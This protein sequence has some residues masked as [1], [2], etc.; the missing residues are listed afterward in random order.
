MNDYTPEMLDSTRLCTGCRKMRYFANDYKI[1]EPC[2]TRDI[3]KY[4]KTVTKCAHPECEFKKSDENEYCGKHQLQVFIKSTAELGKKVCYDHIRG[5]RAQLDPSYPFSKCRDCLDKESASDRKRRHEAM[6]ANPSNDAYKI[7]TICCKEQE[8]SMFV[9]DDDTFTKTCQTCRS[10]NKVQ[11]A[12]RDRD[13]RNLWTRTNLNRAFYSYQRDAEKRDIRFYLT[14]DE[15]MEI[16]K[17]KC[18]Y[19]GDISEEKQFN[20]IDRVDSKGHY[21]IDNCVSACTLCNY[22]KHAMPVE[23]FFQRIEHI[24]TYSGKVNGE[25]HPQ[26]FPNVLSG[27]YD[28]FERNAIDRNF[29]FQLSRTNFSEI[30]KNKC[31]LCGKQ[32]RVNHRNGV[33]RFNNSLGYTIEN[34]RPCCSTC[35]IMKNRYSY[36]DMIGKFEKIYELRIKT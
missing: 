15:F 21:T 3:S 28:T 1:C 30:I 16:I 33:D 8:L 35:N 10:Q 29:E 27:D 9:Y 22:L 36:A 24:L 4:K 25:L 14:K 13:H 17:E 26:A 18:V 11:N 31:Y 32:P 12:R 5:C 2:R 7:C 20:V 6:S 19:C 34:A 23:L